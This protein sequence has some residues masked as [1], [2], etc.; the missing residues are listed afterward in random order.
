[1]NA[2]KKKS[3]KTI[4]VE[5]YRSG[6]GRTKEVKTTLDALGLGRIGK[7]KELP[8][9]PAV[10]GMIKRVSHLVKIVK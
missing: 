6:A 3:E 5:Q 2:E 10:E 4:T 1:M 8:L 7:R 9:N